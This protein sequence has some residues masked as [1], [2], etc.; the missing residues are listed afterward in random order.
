MPTL[1]SSNSIG[2]TPSLHENEKYL[3]YFP[4]TSASGFLLNLVTSVGK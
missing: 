4:K 2:N 1:Y 3:F